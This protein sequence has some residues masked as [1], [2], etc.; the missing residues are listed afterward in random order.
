[1]EACENAKSMLETCKLSA[2][3]KEKDIKWKWQFVSIL[4]TRHFRFLQTNIA[5]RRHRRRS[6]LS[7]HFP[8]QVSWWIRIRGTIEIQSALTFDL[9]TIQCL[10]N[11]SFH[12]IRLLWHQWNWKNGSPMGA[13][14]VIKA[15]QSGRELSEDQN[16]WES[17]KTIYAVNSNGAKIINVFHDVYIGG[18]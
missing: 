5:L 8:S 9:I 7:F 14:T 17:E 16:A 6:T 15:R 1:M 3:G 4:I 10:L 2:C 12:S 11:K 13:I 18:T